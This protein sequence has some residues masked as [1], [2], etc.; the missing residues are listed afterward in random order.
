MPE[1]TFE[2]RMSDTDALM[3]MVEKDPLLRSTIT[4]IALLDHAPDHDRVLAKIERG[5]RLIPRL[6]QRVVAPPFNVAPPEW[7]FDHNFDLASSAYTEMLQRGFKPD[8]PDGTRDQIARIYS[9]LSGTQDH[10]RDLRDMLWSWIDNDTSRDLDQIE[11][12]ER[13]ANGDI[14]IRIGIADVDSAVPKGSPIDVHAAA[15]EGGL[16]CVTWFWL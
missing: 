14:R 12:A 1:R 2:N 6:R 11:V 4:A 3:W 8:F 7:V 16:S 13:L 10:M 15:A 9:S 5:I